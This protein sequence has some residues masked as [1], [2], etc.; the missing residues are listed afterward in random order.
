[1]AQ[2]N[3]MAEKKR[4]YIDGEEIK[5]LVSVGEIPLTKGRIEVPEFKHIRKIQN[6]ISTMPEIPFVYKISRGT[7]TLQFLQDWYHKDEVKEVVL[8]R[9]DAH[10]DEF[11]RTLLSECECVD[12]TDPETDSASPPYA[13]T[14][15]V[16]LPFEITPLAAE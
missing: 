9:V 7:N 1:M 2:N 16:L 13:Q 5:G 10:G 11:A 8:V 12:Y 14:T 4:V 6:G 3:D 15:V